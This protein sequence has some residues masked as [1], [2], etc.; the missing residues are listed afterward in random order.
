MVSPRLYARRILVAACVAVATLGATAPA[1]SSHGGVPVP[2]LNWTDCGDGFECATAK[3]PLDYD[4][5]RGRTTELAL[6][7]KPA[8]DPSTRIG[9]LFM[10]PGGPGGSTFDFLRA[11]ADFAAPLNDRFDLVAW[12]PRGTGLSEQAVDCKVNQE[13]LGPYSQ[14]FPRPFTP[15]EDALTAKTFEYFRR[16]LELNDPR[17]MAHITTVNTARD[18]DLLRRAVG[19][20]KLSYLGFSYGTAI[21]ATY[22]TLFPDKERALVLDGALDDAW[23]NELT[24]VTREQ[25]GGFERAFGRFLQ[26]CAAHQD[27]CLGFGG[28]DPWSA[29]DELVEQLTRTPLEVSDFP[30][31]PLDG[32][33]LLNATVVALYAKQN[34]GIYAV[35]LAQT[36]AGDGNLM[37]FIADLSYGRNDD[38]TYDPASDQFVAVDG[39]DSS[40]EGGPGFYIRAGRHSYRTFDHFWQNSGYAD[41]TF[42]LWP[43]RADDVF[44]GPFENP[45]SAPTALVIGTTYD[46]A[47][48]YRWAESLTRELDNASLLTM[49]GDG[50]TAYGG[51][52]PCID[53]AVEAFLEGV[54]LP[55][56]GTVCRQEV[57]FELPELTATG[58]GATKKA[59]RKLARR[60]EARFQPMR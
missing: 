52:S 16:C 19:D 60:V 6:I 58:A 15:A 35:A 34:W 17:F 33:D 53:A 2:Q 23:F 48:P 44:R 42:G 32:D 47:T 43:V 45:T 37:K 14:P 28:D 9:S 49:R 29:Y 57:P 20:E 10:N 54:V 41:M 1:A 22:A 25:N 11:A 26:A 56:P 24:A 50:H 12:D 55:A 21:G 46:P 31:R 7:R 36:A 3:V 5:P 8:T 30:G 51:N 39:V 13:E 27:V 18:L 59:A 4:R 40:R 38:G